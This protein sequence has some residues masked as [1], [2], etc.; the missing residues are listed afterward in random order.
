MIGVTNLD[1]E[2]WNAAINNIN[3]KAKDAYSKSDKSLSV[4]E[5]GI[6]KV[7]AAMDEMV[8]AFNAANIYVNFM[9]D[10]IFYYKESRRMGR[11]VEG[12]RSYS[13]AGVN[14][15]PDRGKIE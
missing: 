4:T 13:L 11:Q 2:S 7:Q 5:E 8:D 14:I 15:V 1:S 10:L 3:Q 9:D 12:T 6:Q